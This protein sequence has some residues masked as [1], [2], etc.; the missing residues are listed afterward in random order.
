MEMTGLLLT[1]TDRKTSFW[2]YPQVAKFGATSISPNKDAPSPNLPETGGGYKRGESERAH[3]RVRLD[4]SHVRLRIALECFGTERTAQRHDPFTMSN[5]CKP[6]SA[7]N[8]L[9]AH[10]ALHK[11]NLVIR[12][13]ELW[14]RSSPQLQQ[15]KL[16]TRKS[17]IT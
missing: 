12:G 3:Q 16:G 8:R 11:F 10:R 4:P 14:H 9:L 2:T 7:R 17:L 5:S 13:I 1:I 15:L 6:L